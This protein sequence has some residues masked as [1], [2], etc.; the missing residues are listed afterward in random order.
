MKRRAFLKALA[1]G[2]VGALL[3]TAP[4]QLG[5]PDPKPE[6]CTCSPSTGWPNDILATRVCWPCVQE[7][8]KTPG[9]QRW[10]KQLMAMFD[11]HE[12]GKWDLLTRKSPWKV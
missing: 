8:M 5:D 2:T 7:H 10:N 1:A 3:G 4:R 11:R 12:A 9:F 6:G